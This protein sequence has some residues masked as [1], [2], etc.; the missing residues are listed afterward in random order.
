MASPELPFFTCRFSNV[1]MNLDDVNFRALVPL[2]CHETVLSSSLIPDYDESR[3]ASQI[4]TITW[5]TT[6]SQL[7]DLGPEET[8]AWTVS[9]KTLGL[10]DADTG[11]LLT[12]DVEVKID[13]HFIGLTPLSSGPLNHEQA[14]ECACLTDDETDRSPNSL[15]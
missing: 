11:L 8:R 12:G 14:V 1:P 13:T 2:K 3:P 15:N 4:G 7:R 6:P 10:K 5:S 9:A